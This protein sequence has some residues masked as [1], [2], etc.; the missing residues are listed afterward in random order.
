MIRI[1]ES[2]PYNWIG[3]DNFR[4]IERVDQDVDD[5]FLKQSMRIIDWKKS[6][7]FSF[8]LLYQFSMPFY[9]T[10]DSPL[11]W[12]PAWPV[13]FMISP[14]DWS[15]IQDET[16]RIDLN[17]FACSLP[18]FAVIR[19]FRCGAIDLKL[20][21]FLPTEWRPKRQ[22]IKTSDI[23]RRCRCQHDS[24]ER[25]QLNEMPLFSFANKL[26]TFLYLSFE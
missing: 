11:W 3:S 16:R 19:S 4:M 23:I 10:W 6:K 5:T 9:Q 24:I 17:L 8:Y 13:P 25:N 20:N 2:E 1:I 26:A 14:P 21:V 7:L 12:W 22:L 15:V 18:V